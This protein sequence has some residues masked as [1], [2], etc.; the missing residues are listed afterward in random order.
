VQSEIKS[1]IW[2][3]P[4]A[5]S[6]EA[7]QI[8]STNQHR[9][10]LVGSDAI[11]GFIGSEP[12]GGMAW[13]PDGRIVHVSEPAGKADIYILN[14]ERNDDRLLT[15]GFGNNYGPSVSSDGLFIV[16][17]SDRT[18]SANIWRMDLDGR[19]EKQLTFGT[20]DWN[21]MF[22]PDN[23]WVI[24]TSNR[25]GKFSLWK[26]PVDG[27]P[28]TELT[29]YLSVGS[30]VSPR[31]GSILFRFINEHSDPLRWQR[32][33]VGPEGGQ[34][35]SSSELSEFFGIDGASHQLSWTFDGSLI[36]YVIT[37]SGVS[38]IWGEPS[39]GG[40]AKQLTHFKSDVIFSYAWSPDGKR[41]ALGRGS[42]TSNVIL[43]KQL[44]ATL[45]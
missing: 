3:T 37:R 2:V 31:D 38:N 6:D 33:L 30:A 32:A 9:P 27:G 1:D 17:W 28:A 13:T 18:G 23:R 35:I 42:Q 39:Q 14:V 4:V 36:T 7:V 29:N 25:S 16:F 11:R 5:S 21:P 44:N 19:N 41:L 43:I 40:S 24:F 8:T 34:T 15:A 10:S 26:V 22:S 12:I 20:T 45:N